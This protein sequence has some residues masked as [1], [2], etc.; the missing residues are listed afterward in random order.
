MGYSH[1]LVALSEYLSKRNFS[2]WL[3]PV[4]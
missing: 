1:R 2:S 3:L 4:N